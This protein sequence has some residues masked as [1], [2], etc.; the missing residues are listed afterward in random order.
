MIGKSSLFSIR[1]KKNSFFVRRRKIVWLGRKTIPSHLVIN[2]PH[3]ACSRGVI[4]S[5][6]TGYAE[7]WLI[8]LCQQYFCF[9][10]CHL[11]NGFAPAFPPFCQ[12]ILIYKIVN[13][14]CLLLLSLSK[15]Y[16]GV[17]ISTSE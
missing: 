7:T 4:I 3:L 16:S 10:G 14:V 5:R 12:K 17:N 15:F 6:N 11:V 8:T 2:G 13:K 9:V 1:E